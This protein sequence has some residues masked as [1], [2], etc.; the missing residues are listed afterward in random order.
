M[1]SD[2]VKFPPISSTPI[3]KVE[4]FYEVSVLIVS[5]IPLTYSAIY[6]TFLLQEILYLRTFLGVVMLAHKGVI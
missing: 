3:P 4:D 6:F 5:S 2:L 1:A